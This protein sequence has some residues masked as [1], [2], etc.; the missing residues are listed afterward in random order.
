MH[1]FSFLSVFI[2]VHLWLVSDVGRTVL[3]GVRALC[4]T[5]H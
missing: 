3:F 4:W 1:F 5:D 2:G